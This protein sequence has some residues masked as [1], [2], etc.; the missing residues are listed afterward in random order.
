MNAVA[1]SAMHNLLPTRALTPAPVSINSATSTELQAAK[2]LG[3]IIATPINY[4]P[5]V[6]TPIS[7]P[8]LSPL[9]QGYE[10]ARQANEGHHVLYYGRYLFLSVLLLNS[11]LFLWHLAKFLR[12]L[13]TR[14][15]ILR[16]F[17]I[18][19]AALLLVFQGLQTLVVLVYR[20]VSRWNSFLLILGWVL[21]LPSILTFLE[22]GMRFRSKRGGGPFRTLAA[23]LDLTED[24][25][26][27]PLWTLWYS[28]VYGLHV[29]YINLKCQTKRFVP[30]VW[31]AI[32]TTIIWWPYAIAAYLVF[33][34]IGAEGYIN[35]PFDI[36]NGFLVPLESFTAELAA[37]FNHGVPL[38]HRG[39]SLSV[40][41]ILVATKHAG[42]YMLFSVP[43]ASSFWYRIESLYSAA[44]PWIETLPDSMVK[45]CFNVPN[46]CMWA[47]KELGFP[48]LAIRVPMMKAFTPIL[49][50]T[51]RFFPEFP[52][53]ALLDLDGI[54]LATLIS[55]IFFMVTV[56]SYIMYGKLPLVLESLISWIVHVFVD[57][58]S[59]F[60]RWTGF[61]QKTVRKLNILAKVNGSFLYPLALGFEVRRRYGHLILRYLRQFKD[62]GFWQRNLG[63]AWWF[64]RTYVRAIAPSIF[65]SAWFRSLLGIHKFLKRNLPIL[66]SMIRRGKLPCGLSLGKAVQL[67]L[68]AW[69]QQILAPGMKWRMEPTSPLPD[70][71]SG[72]LLLYNILEV[73]SL[74][75]LR[76]RQKSNLESAVIA[77]CYKI[78][79]SI[80]WYYFVHLLFSREMA[81]TFALLQH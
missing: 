25:S 36:Y 73:I 71:V 51:Y 47:L 11:I 31:E 21:T 41:D 38:L 75:R 64:I 79:G 59:R 42:L 67:V 34:Q 33:R 23:R 24:V 20:K 60:I 16:P 7:T 12:L 15:R 5:P 22:V 35:T 27:L 39:P 80:I 3:S 6:P 62:R 52:A 76:L 69:S 53:Q 63:R 58:H 81:A 40:I 1:V 10:E 30:Q 45:T 32:R 46:D 18:I 55:S 72:A 61:D 56:I 43:F 19:L 77:V 26:V 65:L 2:K 17:E 74:I 78:L 70:V 4:A 44:W 68:V 37:R 9:S 57:F 66:L 13:P 14:S 54:D 29:A 28:H 48:V 49:N 8:F 50:K